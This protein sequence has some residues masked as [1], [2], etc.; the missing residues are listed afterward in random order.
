MP[1]ENFEQIRDGADCERF[2]DEYF[3]DL[4][5]LIGRERLVRDFFSLKPQYLVSIKVC[6]YY[7]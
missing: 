7:K 6:Y 3:A 2:F 5:P 4:I 1:F